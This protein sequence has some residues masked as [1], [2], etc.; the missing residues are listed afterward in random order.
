MAASWPNAVGGSVTLHSAT[1]F[2][3]KEDESNT[4]YQRAIFERNN[5]GQLWSEEAAKKAALTFAAGSLEV[6]V[7]DTGLAATKD[8]L[9]LPFAAT[10]AGA[11]GLLLVPFW[12]PKAGTN[13]AADLVVIQ[14]AIDDGTYSVE[15]AEAA[16]VKA[17]ADGYE[18]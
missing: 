13:Y 4:G 15:E 14:E 16:R 3:W 10:P 7:T 12:K 1:G 9:N 8:V 18:T 5:V 17:L 2:R 6:G 11:D